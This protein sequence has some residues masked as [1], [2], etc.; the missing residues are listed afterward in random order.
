MLLT[1][2]ASL[3]LLVCDERRILAAGCFVTVRVKFNQRFTS[4]DSYPFDPSIKILKLEM[5][6]SGG[7]SV[8]IIIIIKVDTFVIV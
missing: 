2:L 6:T 4:I 3:A 5:G 8:L 1:L 7:A